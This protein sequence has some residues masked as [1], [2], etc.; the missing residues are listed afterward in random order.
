MIEPESLK[1]A[2]TVKVRGDHSVHRPADRD[3]DEPETAL[4]TLSKTLAFFRQEEGWFGDKEQ[5]ESLGP[6]F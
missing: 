4:D 2:R 6:N 5:W 3:F 1:L